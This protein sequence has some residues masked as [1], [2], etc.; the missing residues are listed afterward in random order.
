MLHCSKFFHKVT[1]LLV[2][3]SVPRLI[4]YISEDVGLRLCPLFDLV[5][6][7]SELCHHFDILY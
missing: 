4:D 6:V 3:H 7:A 5:S 1:C 2:V